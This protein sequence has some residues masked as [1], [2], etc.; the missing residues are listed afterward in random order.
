M[1]T[2]GGGGLIPFTPPPDPKWLSLMDRFIKV[3]KIMEKIDKYIDILPD[4]SSKG[5]GNQLPKNYLDN[6]LKQQGLKNAPNGL[7]QT[8][9][10][11]GYKYEVR[12]H[13]GESQYT[14][15]NSIYRVSRQQIP[16]PGTQGTGTQY[17]GTDGNWYHTSVLRQF[18]G[19]GSLNPLYNANAAQ[20][21]HIP[22]P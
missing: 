22:L 8:W 10:E 4:T 18:N 15:A 5:A 1:H 6:A 2:G 9:T 7:K 16:T 17:L 14:N 19:D 11:N 21:T 20:I 12:V 13:T 3:L